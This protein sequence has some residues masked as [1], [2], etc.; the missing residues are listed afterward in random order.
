MK[1]L[2]IFDL[3]GTL[4]NT[5]TDLGASTNFALAKMGYPEHPLSAYN[6]MVGNGVQIGRAHV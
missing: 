3:D 6:Y 5:I 4:L 1:R 2:A